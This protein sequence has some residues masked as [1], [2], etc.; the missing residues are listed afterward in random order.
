MLSCQ[1]LPTETHSKYAYCY[2]T[3]A[4]KAVTR[5]RAIHQTD[6]HAL[7][8]GLCHLTSVCAKLASSGMHACMHAGQGCKG[9]AHKLSGAG[10]TALSVGS[11]E[12]HASLCAQSNLLTNSREPKVPDRCVGCACYKPLYPR[13]CSV[14]KTKDDAEKQSKG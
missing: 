12:V 13:L 5:S 1:D 10:H 3:V 2:I 4:A 6:K 9:A 11:C 14:F 8:K 7:R